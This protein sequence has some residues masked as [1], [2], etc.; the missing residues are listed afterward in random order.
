MLH[1]LKI[2]NFC[3]FREEQ[4]FR[5]DSPGSTLGDRRFAR[6][7]GHT[8]TALTAMVFGANASG[9]T[10]F[11]RALPFLGWFIK[12]SWTALKPEQK[13]PFT[14]F[15]FSNSKIEPTGFEICVESEAGNFYIY[16]L[17]L[18]CN[19]VLVESLKI[20]NPEARGYSS[21]FKRYSAKYKLYPKAQFKMGDIPKKALRNNASFISTAIQSNISVFDDFL[22]AFYINSNID[23]LD[24]IDIA[25]ENNLYLDK[26]YNDESLK[27]IVTDII[28][29]CDTGIDAIEIIQEDLSEQKKINLYNTINSQFF[30]NLDKD[31]FKANSKSYMANSVHIISDNKYKLPLEYESNGI[32][33]LIPFITEIISSINRGGI[34]VF[35]EIE[36]GLH[37]QLVKFLLELFYDEDINT[38]HAQLI[39]SSHS[40]DCLNFL[41]KYQIFITVKDKTQSSC[42]TR[43]CDI[44]GVRN[45]DNLMQKYLSGTYGGVPDID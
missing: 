43:L 35:D 37:P 5:L 15:L 3:S 41:A 31:N 13:I 27:N 44:G 16:Q 26:L 9:K 32:K 11:L 12:N 33:K 10:N 42:I 18:D 36:K 22:S 1:C 2:K 23:L 30:F 17:E 14:P 24:V 8:T 20:K 29:K 19:T 7:S 21:L 6:G 38:R 4:E 25:N 34:L 39:C 45:D 40:A 28:K